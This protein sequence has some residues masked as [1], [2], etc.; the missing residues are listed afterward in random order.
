VEGTHHE[1]VDDLLLPHG[2]QGKGPLQHSSSWRL[3]QCQRLHCCPPRVPSQPETESAPGA[4]GAA[5]CST[6]SAWSWKGGRELA[7]VLGSASAGN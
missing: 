2:P 6:C 4:P 5:E 1:R 3:R 7:A